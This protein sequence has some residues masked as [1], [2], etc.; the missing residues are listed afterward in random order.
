LSVRSSSTQSC[1]FV[2]RFA[3]AVLVTSLHRAP[4]PCYEASSGHTAAT[5]RD[6]ASRP[7][8]SSSSGRRR[9]ET[10][11]SGRH[12]RL[13]KRPPPPLDEAAACRRSPRC[14]CRL[15]CSTRSKIESIE[16]ARLPFDGSTSFIGSTPFVGSA[17]RLSFFN[18]L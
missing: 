3:F 17:C 13:T 8:L 16:A 6:G 2:A 15:L 10:F 7:L 18:R 12:R 5:S 14:R 11:S 1:I 4:P 9:H